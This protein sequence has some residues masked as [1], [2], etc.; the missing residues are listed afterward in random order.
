MNVV[1]HLSLADSYKWKAEQLGGV[2]TFPEEFFI[3]QSEA[4]EKFKRNG[5]Y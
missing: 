4:I 5:E 3:K 2:L 1:Y